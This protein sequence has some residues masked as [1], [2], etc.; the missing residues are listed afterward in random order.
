MNQSRINELINNYYVERES[1]KI[2]SI[3]NIDMNQFKKCRLDLDYSNGN[4]FI[5]NSCINAKKDFG[6]FIVD[7]GYVQNFDFKKLK[8]Q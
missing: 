8:S 1:N 3:E 2:W 6:L 4:S 7:Y 5:N